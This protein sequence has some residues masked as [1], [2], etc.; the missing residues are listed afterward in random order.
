MV[1]TLVAKNRIKDGFINQFTGINEGRKTALVPDEAPLI[2]S[3]LDLNADGSV[4]RR[5]PAQQLIDFLGDLT[6]TPGEV[7]GSMCLST[8]RPGAS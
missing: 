1:E 6:Y 7:Y 5:V 8:G 3:N 4:S 2:L